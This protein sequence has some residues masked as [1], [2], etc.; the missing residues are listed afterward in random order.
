MQCATDIY[1]PSMDVTYIAFTAK[2]TNDSAWHENEMEA[3]TDL[4]NLSC[5][6]KQKQKQKQGDRQVKT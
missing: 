1:W 3:F 2:S 4:P 5:T 6:Q